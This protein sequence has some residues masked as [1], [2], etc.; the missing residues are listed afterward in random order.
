ML[1]G[2]SFFL[3]GPQALSGA[4][5]SQQATR[6]AAGTANGFLGIFCYLSTL[7]SG[8]LFGSLADNYGWNAV[9]VC[10]A[11]FGLVGSV[12]MA[13]MWKAPADAYDKLDKII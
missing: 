1:V 9:F 8:V 4:V 6:Y 12:I 10:A 3:Y 5:A 13:L 2:A 7:V 11:I